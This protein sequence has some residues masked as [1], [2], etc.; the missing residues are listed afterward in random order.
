MTPS[1][2]L[3]QGVTLVRAYIATMPARERDVL[4]RLL[5]KGQ[6]ELEVSRALEIPLVAVRRHRARAATAIRESETIAKALPY[7]R[8]TDEPRRTAED[9]VIERIDRRSGNLGAALLP[10]RD[11]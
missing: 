9:R 8:M 4:E 7:L 10:E 11:A 5:L 2:R 6:T 3:E 1:D